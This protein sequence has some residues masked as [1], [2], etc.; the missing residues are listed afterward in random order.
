MPPA[1]FSVK[2]RAKERYKMMP[3]ENV[4]VPLHGEDGLNE[5]MGATQNKRYVVFLSVK[6]EAADALSKK[7]RTSCLES[8]DYECIFNATTEEADRWNRLQKQVE[9]DSSHPETNG[10]ILSCAYCDFAVSKKDVYYNISRR[11]YDFIVQHPGIILVAG[12][13]KEFEKE[14]LGKGLL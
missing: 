12:C 1:F 14:L 8:Q 9:L 6:P 13:T 2:R 4:E 5:A 3:T 7:L 10:R 11:F